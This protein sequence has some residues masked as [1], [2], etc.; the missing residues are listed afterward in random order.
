[1]HGSI[2]GK[3]DCLKLRP[4]TLPHRRMLVQL[5]DNGCL[6]RY[7]CV[8][9]HKEK[10]A[11]MRFSMGKRHVWPLPNTTNEKEYVCRDNNFKKTR[12][13]P[14]MFGKNNMK[15]PK[16]LVKSNNHRLVS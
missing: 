4:E 9:I 7:S 13:V 14:S 6:P 1:M 16:L 11:L 10:S 3:F 15:P 12:N 5:F 8:Q 2:M